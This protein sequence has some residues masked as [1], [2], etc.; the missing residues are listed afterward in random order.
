[1]IYGDPGVGKTSLALTYPRPFVINTDF[2]LEGDAVHD[3][4]DILFAEPTGYKDTEDVAKWL[5]AHPER[6]DTIVLDAEDG[7]STILMNEMM[8]KT[9]KGG[10][11]LLREVVPETQDY[12]GN[13]KQM[14]RIIN[15]LRRIPDKHVVLTSGVR[16]PEG[17]KRSL[18]AAPGLTQIINR[19]ASLIGEL[20]VVRLDGDGNL[21]QQGGTPTRVL[22]LDP[23][24][25]KRECKSRWVTLTPYV[26]NPTFDKI[27]TL[28]ASEG[29]K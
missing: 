6:Y 10:E 4:D 1:V 25:K 12:L 11:D 20:V 28:K 3:R 24:S 23:S 16:E 7:L 8:D 15:T 5:V 27:Q 26:E 29:N 17:R 13:Q 22:M 9:K 21:V 14:E 2:G 18:N 19:W